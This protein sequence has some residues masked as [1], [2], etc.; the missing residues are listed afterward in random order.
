MQGGGGM[1]I[2]NQGWEGQVPAK[3]Q[4]KNC[5]LPIF[6]GRRASGKT[7]PAYLQKYVSICFNHF[8]IS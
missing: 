5:D 7:S 8:S 3:G 2:P 4:K 1:W 6:D